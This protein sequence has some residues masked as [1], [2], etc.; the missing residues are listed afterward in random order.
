MKVW[1]LNLTGIVFVSL[2]AY[3][4]TATILLLIDW[5]DNNID[6]KSNQ[7]N[8]KTILGEFSDEQLY[9]YFVTKNEMLQLEFKSSLA[10]V[11]YLKEKISDVEQRMIEINNK[12]ILEVEFDKEK[13]DNYARILN[14]LHSAYETLMKKIHI[15]EMTL[16]N[17]S[18]NLEILKAEISLKK[19]SEKTLFA[20]KHFETHVT[21]TNNNNSMLK[22]I[23]EKLRI[24]DAKLR[25]EIE[26]TKD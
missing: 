3:W 26:L 1:K 15:L 11:E 12:N 24:L 8:Q 10:S 21:K 25:S 2:I 17:V 16:A 22:D 19:T 7:K 13:L 4:A 23:D 18:T 14:R 9:S 6:D 20:L 5:R